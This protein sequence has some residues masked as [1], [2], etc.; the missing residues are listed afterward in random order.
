[1]AVASL[2]RWLMKEWLPDGCGKSSEPELMLYQ[3]HP[4]PTDEL[5]K[6]VGWDLELNSLTIFPGTR[7]PRRTVY[8]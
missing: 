3:R 8:D 6:L 1:M 5:P 4:E 2:N 7:T